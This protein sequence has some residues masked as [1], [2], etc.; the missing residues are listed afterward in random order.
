GRVENEGC[1]ELELAPTL[2]ELPVTGG[3]ASS[4]TVDVPAGSYASLEAKIAPVG[5]STGHHGAGSS[6]FLAAHPDLAGVSVRVEGTFDGRPFVYVG[7]PWARLES[8]FDP[9]LTVASGGASL[10]VAVDL[11]SWFRAADGSLIDPATALPGTVVGG[12]VAGNVVRSFAAF[13]DDDR[14]GRDDSGGRDHSSS[15]ADDGAGDDRGG[16]A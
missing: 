15:G 3:V 12:I 6:A 8:V 2:V 14:D 9:P 11:A 13:R 10:T 1:A 7:A 5:A 4:L 16:D